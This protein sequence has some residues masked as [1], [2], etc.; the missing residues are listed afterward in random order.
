MKIAVMGAGAVGCYYGAMLAR[1]GHEVVLIGR[2]AL[3]EAVQANG[4]I[5]EMGGESHVIA[6]EVSD[7]PAAI[8]G[9][10]MVLFCVK[11]SDTEDAG[12]QIAPYLSDDTLLLSLQNGVSNPER[13]QA[14]TGHA[15]IP[16][17]VYVASAMAGPG[18]VRHE[19]R[20][21]L[22]IGGPGSD[23]AAEVLNGAGVETVVSPDIIAAQWVKL[24]L[25]CAYNA[26]SAVADMPYG[27]LVAQDGIPELLEDNVAECRA[28]A[29]AAGV[30]LPDGLLD[31][32]RGIAKAMPGQYSS[33]AQ[34][35]RRGRM[36]EIDFLN[37]EIVRKGRE[38]GVPTPINKTLT[39]LVKLAETKLG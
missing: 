26:L 8:A 30:A 1:A 36:T 18:V 22:A 2:P 6:V 31:N 11:S 10:G 20:G 5:L 28:V 21:D 27:P 15:V 14:V 12:R 4:L 13:L 3:V 39:A 38:L 35:L 29:E 24:I 7:D 37:G 9:A 34:D 17:V 33:T 19:G 23:A 25:N 16:T 32:V